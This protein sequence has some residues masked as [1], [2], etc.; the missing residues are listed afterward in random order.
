MVGLSEEEDDWGL[1][2]SKRTDSEKALQDRAAHARRDAMRISFV[3]EE[4]PRKA[5]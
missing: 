5:R 3:P 1:H 2:P 4:G